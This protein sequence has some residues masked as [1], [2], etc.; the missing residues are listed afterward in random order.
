[1]VTLSL[2]FQLENK[3]G[4]LKEQV[5]MIKPLLDALRSK[6]EER[7]KELMALQAQIT[8][9]SAEIAGNVHNTRPAQVDEL[10]L[11]VKKLSE[12]SSQL[13]ELQKE[14]VVYFIN[15]IF[16]LNTFLV[17]ILALIGHKIAKGECICCIYP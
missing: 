8:L 3:K 1:M 5:A 15:K 13:E 12:L 17:L 9:L 2:L 4:T 7:I 11:S 14:K 10:D 16:Q 6:R